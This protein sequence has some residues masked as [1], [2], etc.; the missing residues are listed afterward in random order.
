LWWEGAFNK[1][2]F[3]TD[4]IYGQVPQ[5]LAEDKARLDK[6]NISQKIQEQIFAK[7]IL[8]MLGEK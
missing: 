5:I 7:N 1:I 6:Y 8:K 4:V 2:V 3:G